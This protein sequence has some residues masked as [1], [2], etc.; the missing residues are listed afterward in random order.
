MFTSP[1]PQGRW[2]I[3][4]CGLTAAWKAWQKAEDTLVEDR[5][6]AGE[7]K[8]FDPGWATRP[9][10]AGA[11][12]APRLSA[13][14][15]PPDTPIWTLAGLLRR[16]PLARKPASP[17][18]QRLDDCLQK[19]CP[20]GRWAQHRRFPN[21]VGLIVHRLDRALYRHL[22]PFRGGDIGWRADGLDRTVVGP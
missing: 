2:G 4:F 10:I 6:A 1:L 21:R 18:K 3:R 19:G 9:A 7:A 11:G 15:S 17:A 5:K 12:V 14:S 20:A 8:A 13:T 16:H 22:W